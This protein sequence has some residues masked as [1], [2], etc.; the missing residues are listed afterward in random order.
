M[1]LKTP[2]FRLKKD[3]RALARANSIPLH[4]AL[5][6]TAKRHGFQSWSHL[7]LTHEKPAFAIKVWQSLSPGDMI[8]L[9]AR[10]GQGKTLLA[11]QIIAEAVAN[12][13][14]TA[15]FTLEYHEADIA[16]CLEKAGLAS[17]IPDAGFS[18]DTSDSISA[19]HVS[20]KLTGYEPGSLA[21]IDYLQLLDQKRQNP[22]VNDQLETLAAFAKERELKIILIS[23]IDR[24]FDLSEK[25]FP[26]LSDVRRPNPFETGHFTRSCFLHDGQMTLEALAR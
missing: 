8:L 26:D 12:G 9:A 13:A 17:G 3:A 6:E 10:P 14:R 19:D 23:Q 5:D 25:P 20:E 4:E 24:K 16:A 21:V 22:E 2:I 18:F 11:L 7:S 1:Q 15:F